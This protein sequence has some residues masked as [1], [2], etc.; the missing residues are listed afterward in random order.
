MVMTSI[1]CVTPH[2]T[3]EGAKHEK[4]GGEGQIAAAAD[5]V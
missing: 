5:E 2:A 4:N 1:R 3:M